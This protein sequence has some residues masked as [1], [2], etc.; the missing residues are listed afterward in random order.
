MTDQEHEVLTARIAKAFHETYRVSS[1]R[2]PRSIEIT[3]DEALGAIRAK[4]LASTS[5]AYKQ[6]LDMWLALYDQ[7]VQ[8]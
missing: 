3:F 8:P 6:H 5:P 7:T 1:S 2:Q 4:A